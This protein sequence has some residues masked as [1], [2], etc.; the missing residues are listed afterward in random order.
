MFLL[1]DCLFSSEPNV[2]PALR[3]MY[4]TGAVPCT[5]KTAYYELMRDVRILRDP[6]AGGPR[7]ERLLA[8]FGMPEEWLPW[9]PKL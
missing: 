7:W 9:E 3:R 1:E 8:D 6:A 2:G 5:L 4:A